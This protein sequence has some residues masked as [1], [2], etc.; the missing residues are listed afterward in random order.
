MFIK[1]P[2]YLNVEGTNLSSDVLREVLRN[3]VEM[4]LIGPSQSVTM[5]L[6]TNDV[7]VLN[8]HQMENVKVTLLKQEKVL[9]GLR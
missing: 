1:V 9:D 4:Y 6:K 8:Q 3:R 5:E 7:R 2:I